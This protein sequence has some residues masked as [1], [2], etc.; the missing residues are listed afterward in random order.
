[1]RL[2]TLASAR[3]LSEY[4]EY[5]RLA[6]R[7][8]LLPTNTALRRK[9]A[10]GLVQLYVEGW[11]RPQHRDMPVDYWVAECVKHFESTA[12]ALE[13]LDGLL[14]IAPRAV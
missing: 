11:L 2:E 14:I 13:S 10:E 3:M 8:V 12:V 1:M 9:V 5:R 7:I 4:C 6:R